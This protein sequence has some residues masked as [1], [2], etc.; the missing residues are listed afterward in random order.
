MIGFSDLPDPKKSRELFEDMLG[1]ERGRKAYRLTLWLLVPL[2]VAAIALT[3]VVLIGGR[4]DDIARFIE[5]TYSEVTTSLRPPE[6]APM[7]PA[8]V[9]LHRS[10]TKKTFQQ[11]VA[12]YKDHPALQGDVFTANEAGKWINAE[13]VVRNLT[14]G[15]GV[16]FVEDAVLV[17]CSFDERWIAKLNAFRLDD[18]IKVVGK[19]SRYKADPRIDLIALTDCEFRN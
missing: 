1:P 3:C 2:V 4:L 13:G 17:E 6:P 10:F 9:P 15:S 19:I 18:T 8:P 11:L 7:K 5:T 12:F 16:L 14:G